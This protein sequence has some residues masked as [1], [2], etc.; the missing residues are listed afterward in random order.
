M[1]KI[2]PICGKQFETAK[3]HPWQKFCSKECA[4]VNTLACSRA[5]RQRYR[6]IGH[7]KGEIKRPAVPCC[8]TC[9]KTFEQHFPNEKFCSEDC[10]LDFFSLQDVENFFDFIR[11]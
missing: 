6:K 3:C 11:G 1:I 10:R 2:C 4:H 9:G 8:R 5:A 7:N